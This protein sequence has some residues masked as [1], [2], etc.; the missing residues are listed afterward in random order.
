MTGKE[1]SLDLLTNHVLEYL[2]ISANK[3]I[4]SNL[5]DLCAD[6]RKQ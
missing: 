6:T 2:T 4:Y 5:K 3:Q 1:M